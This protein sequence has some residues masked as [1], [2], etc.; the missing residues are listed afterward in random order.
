VNRNIATIAEN[1]IIALFPFW[2]KYG[3]LTVIL[4]YRYDNP[5]FNFHLPIG[6]SCIRHPLQ[7]YQYHGMSELSQAMYRE[8]SGNLLSYIY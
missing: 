1:Y 2:L 5:N 8:F 4:H 3:I 7:L 6:K